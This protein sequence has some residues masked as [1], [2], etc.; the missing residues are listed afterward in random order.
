MYPQLFFNKKWQISKNI[1]FC[2]KLGKTATE[3]YK[4]SKRSLAEAAI[5][6]T[7]NI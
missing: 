5:S 3:T 4:M 6:I 1:T 7:Q 2:F